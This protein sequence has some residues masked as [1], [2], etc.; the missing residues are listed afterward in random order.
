MR[1]NTRLREMN[2]AVS[3]NDE[4][5]RSVGFWGAFAPRSAVG[6]RC[7]SQMCPHVRR[8]RAPPSS[9]HERGG[10][11]PCP[12]GQGEE[13]RRTPRVRAL[14]IGGRR[15]GDGGG[16]GARKRRSSW[17]SLAS[18]RAREAPRIL[19][20]STFSGWRRRWSWMLCR[21]VCQGLRC[22]A[23]GLASGRTLR[24]RRPS[25]DLADLFAM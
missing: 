7:H 5:H 19:W 17:D 8:E 16:D 23:G 6:S 15:T 20:R 12:S 2:V 10:P 25:P 4:V 13:V 14:P 18:A 22:F 11:D 1:F 24:D 21:L 9:F 3:A